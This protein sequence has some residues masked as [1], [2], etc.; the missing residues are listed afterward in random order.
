MTRPQVLILAGTAATGKSTIAER[1]LKEFGTQLPQLKFV[2]GDSLHPKA[3]V[4]KMS[5]GIPL[6]DEDRWGWLKTVS[7]DGSKTA[8]EN[9]NIAIVSCSS[10]KKKYRDLIREVSPDTDFHFI[11]LYATKKEVLD[12]LHKRSNHFMKAN[13]M[14]SQFRDLELPESSEPLCYIVKLDGK[15]FVQIEDDVVVVTKNIL[16]LK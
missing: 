7:E 16:H 2:E 1:L 10:L 5:A 11:F 15:T 3:N 4:D 8:K 12:R 13:M 14:E 9:G 6:E